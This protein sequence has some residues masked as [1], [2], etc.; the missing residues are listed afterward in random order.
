MCKGTFPRELLQLSNTIES[1]YLGFNMFYGPLPS[2]LG[3]MSKLEEL[4]LYG[5]D[6]FSTIP[7]QVARLEN[8]NTLGKLEE[9]PSVSLFLRT[10]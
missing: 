3:E 2:E 4:N 10:F 5:N 8:L 1:I 6:F 7:P 9:F